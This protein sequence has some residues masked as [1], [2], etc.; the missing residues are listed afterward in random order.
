MSLNEMS[1]FRPFKLIAILCVFLALC[2]DVVA[3]LSPAWVTAERYALSLW[4]SC[5]EVEDVWQCISTLSSGKLLRF[6]SSF[7]GSSGIGYLGSCMLAT[8]GRQ[9]VDM[10]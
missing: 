2:L 3:V 4:E 1:V 7:H 5:R 6:S 8:N 10:S 9:V